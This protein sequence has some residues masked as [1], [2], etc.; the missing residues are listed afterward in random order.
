VI[1]V[2]SNAEIS[3]ALFED[4]PGHLHRLLKY[5]GCDGRNTLESVRRPA[6]LELGERMLNI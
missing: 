5:Y 6:G 1:L 2:S 4:L 3:T